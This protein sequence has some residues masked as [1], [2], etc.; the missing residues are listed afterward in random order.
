[1]VALRLA[2]VASSTPTPLPVG[3]WLRQAWST[4]WAAVKPY[5]ADYYGAPRRRD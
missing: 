4:Y 5:I 2:Y 3:R 1:M